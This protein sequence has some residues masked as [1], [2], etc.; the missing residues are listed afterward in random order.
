MATKKTNVQADYPD[1][2]D[3]I[4][5]PALLC[6]EPE[7]PPYTDVDILDQKNEGACTGFAL[8]AAINLLNRRARVP[9]QVSERM[10]YEM[11]KRHDEWA[12]EDYGGSSLR[13][14][15]HGFRQMGVCERQLW[16]YRTQPAEHG[17]LTIERAKAARK[18]TP[19]AY[20]RLRPAVSDYHAA[21]LEVGVVVASTRYHS[22]WDKPIDGVISKQVT[23]PGGHAFAII[24]YNTRGF[25]VQNSWGKKWGDH[26]LALWTYEDWI[27][28]VMDAWV[29]RLALPTPQ[30]FGM[31][32]LSSR[33][34]NY[35][36]QP[37]AST[38]VAKA[39]MRETI[40]GHFVHIDDGKFATTDRYWSTAFDVQQTAQ[41]VAK[42]PD[43]QHLLVYGHGGL[44]SPKDSAKRI[45]AM[46]PVF[47]A[48]GIYPYHV[49]YDTGLVE[50]LKDILMGKSD[51][52]RQMVGGFG[53]WLDRMIEHISRRPGRLLWHE[54][55]QDAEQAF[56]KDGAGT[57]S[58][59]YFIQAMQNT[60]GTPVKK[61]HLAGHSTGAVLFA[62]LLNTL[63]N[64][65]LVFESCTLLAPACTVDLYHK[66]YLRILEGKH[67]LRLK[68][69]KILN[70]KDRLELDDTVVSNM[71]YRKSL[72]YLVSNAFERVAERPLLGME[73]FKSQLETSEHGPT[74]IYSNGVSGNK[75][76]STSHGGFDNDVRTMNYLLKTILGAEP[77]RFFTKSDLEF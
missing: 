36:D 66:T 13:G 52:A 7:A 50:E 11:A 63:K 33:V 9:L 77:K 51:R 46:K 58:L 55:K 62:H 54:M 17:E 12:G 43:Y 67:K 76:R 23:E 8:A 42:S 44:N 5:R 30:I 75:T 19:G 65:K 14:A 41:L 16:P 69:M 26:G 38:I 68:Q 48:N 31:R 40:A 45:A 4:Y 57:E 34:I 22:G 74:I 21:L 56:A 60:A 29:F 64:D 70:L 39:P 47:I 61:L 2:R 24:G 49:M 18:T 15:I 72:L 71:V 53:D 73:K 25:W 27:E 37:E 20:Y 1:S 35:R 28:N 6:L 3:W 59:K 32:P 10:L